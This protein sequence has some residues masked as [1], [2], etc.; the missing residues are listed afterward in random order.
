MKT[1]HYISLDDFTSH[2]SLRGTI[3]DVVRDMLIDSLYA[4]TSRI[5]NVIDYFLNVYFIEL[6]R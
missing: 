4:N 3:V 5:P 1:I 6:I 2:T